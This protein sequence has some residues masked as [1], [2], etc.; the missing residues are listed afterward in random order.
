MMRALVLVLVLSSCT[1]N[2]IQ[3]V[4]AVPFDPPPVYGE[5]YAQ[6]AVCVGELGDFSQVKW[7]VVPHYMPLGDRDRAGRWVAPHRIYVAR[8][9]LGR[10]WVIRHESLHDLL[11]DGSHPTP[12]FTICDTPNA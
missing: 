2:I 11:Q 6:T 9:E 5:W 12:P 1:T 8:D 7:F 10:E 3:V 4:D